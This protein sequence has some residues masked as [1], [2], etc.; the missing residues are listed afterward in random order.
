M[1]LSGAIPAVWC[2]MRSW[3]KEQARGVA[4]PYI[5]VMHFLSLGAMAWAGLVTWE[6]GV[7]FLWG[8]P[9]I[10]IGTVVGIAL[11]RRL[12]EQL[13]RRLVLAMLAVSGLTLVI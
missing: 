8:A 5:L 11:Y 3:P 12:N 7:R 10:I 6:T 13:F 9:A 2:G 1:V 4:Q